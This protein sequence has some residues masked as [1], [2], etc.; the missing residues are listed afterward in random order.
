MH[1]HTYIQMNNKE[2]RVG[3]GEERE[4][5]GNRDLLV[6]SKSFVSRRMSSY[7]CMDEKSGAEVG[8][9]RNREREDGQI[10]GRVRKARNV[11][12]SL[13]IPLKADDLVPS[14]E[15]EDA[16]VRKGETRKG[17]RER[18]RR[19]FVKRKKGGIEELRSRLLLSSALGK[20]A[21]A[22]L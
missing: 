15:D 20:G 2:A 5:L 14:G 13:M 7:F 8:G 21:R 22:P 4:E 6:C 16:A 11:I 19:V 12:P 18:G 1:I 10:R 17:H 9:E 3:E